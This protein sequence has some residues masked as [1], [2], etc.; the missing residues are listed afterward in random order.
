MESQ[1]RGTLHLHILLWLEN[2]PTAE[3]M[4]EKLKSTE[5]RNKVAEFIKQNLRAYL[6]GLESADTVKAIPREKEIAF[7]RPPN[8]DLPDYDQRLS[9][10]EL[11]VARMEQVHTCH[12]GRCLKQNA[13][14]EMYCKRRAPF[15]VSEVDAVNQNGKW[16]QKRSYEYING[17]IPGVLINARC[18]NDGKLLTNG[19]DTKNVSFYSTL[20]AAKKQGNNY[21]SSA[22]MADGYA[23]HLAHL[24]QQDTAHLDDVRDVQ[25]LM[26]FRLVNSLNREQELAAPMVISY[27]MGWGDSYTSHHYTP[28]FWSSFI[29]HLYKLYPIL[30]RHQK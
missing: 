22:V 7:N 9:D 26:L 21:N 4:V 1:G 6:P 14:G 13:N 15:Q 17:W 27:L 3:E 25:R 11:R 2:A 10:F 8:P 5:F 24:G 29:G 12:L 19:E 20:Y 30:H 23:Y 18:N 16:T 28:I